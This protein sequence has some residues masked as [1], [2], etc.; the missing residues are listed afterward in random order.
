MN[1]ST[2]SF[3]K[4]GARLLIAPHVFLGPS[5]ITV[6]MWVSSLNPVPAVQGLASFLL[7]FFAWWS[8]WYWQQTV[9][10]GLPLFSAIAVMYW[11][12]FAVPLFWGNRYVLNWRHPGRLLTNSAV[13][14]AML[15]VVFGVA[16]LWLGM[17]STLGRRAALK[18]FP[19]VSIKPPSLVYLQA[20]AIVGTLMTSYGDLQSAGGEGWRQV[21]LAIQGTASLAA[22]VILLWRAMNGKAGRLERISLWGILAFRVVLGVSTGWMGLAVSLGLVCALVYLQN[23]RKLPI[24]A[25]ACLVPYVLFFQAGKTQ[26]RSAFWYGQMQANTIQK[27]VFW[28]DASLKTWR[29]ALEDPSGGGVQSLLA[30][31]LSRTSLLA[32]TANV[33]EQTP[34]VVPYQYGR[35]YSYLAV[36]LIPRFLWPDKPSMSEANQFYQLS[37]GLTHPKDLGRVSISVGALTEGFISFGWFGTA[38]VMFLVGALLDFWNE[39]FLNKSSTI[40]AVGIGVALVPLLLTVE[41]QLAQ[42]AS[43]ILQHILITILM[44]LPITHWPR[45]VRAV[46]RSVR[47]SGLSRRDLVAAD[48]KR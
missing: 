14:E 40:L 28:V 12:Y 18:R 37:Y 15:L 46:E 7:L 27:V 23:T 1:P 22:V 29:L 41:S 16:F 2:P 8:Y 26:F 36:S 20:M 39:T 48:F 44:F 43:G 19:E 33:I 45:K 42:Y 6:F 9:C 10:N 25:M 35:L 31:S 5:F 11:L 32:Q 34:D 30:L 13:S 3:R 24:V 21:I 38:L 47:T 4:S 17:R